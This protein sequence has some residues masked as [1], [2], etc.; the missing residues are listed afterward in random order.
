ME[1]CKRERERVR[2]M[3]YWNMTVPY[4]SFQHL[5]G[6]Q[7]LVIFLLYFRWVGKEFLLLETVPHLP[8]GI[9]PAAHNKIITGCALIRELSKLRMLHCGTSAKSFQTL[10]TTDYC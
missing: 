5:Q 1:V 2:E 3:V 7:A 4:L 9:Q 10:P 8:D 6:L